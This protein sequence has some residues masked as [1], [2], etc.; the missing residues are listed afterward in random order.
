[1]E[2]SK[3]ATQIRYARN[4]KY[5][6]VICTDEGF[7]VTYENPNYEYEYSMI[8]PYDDLEKSQ[9]SEISMAADHAVNWVNERIREY[10]EEELSKI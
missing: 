7:K 6:D 1:M 10:L 3:L 8:I 5:C 9:L 2:M 4:C